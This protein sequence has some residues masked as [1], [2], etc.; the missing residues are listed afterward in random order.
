MVSLRQPFN[1]RLDFT[2]GAIIPEGAKVVRRLGDMRDMYQDREAVQR[3]LDGG[4]P[5]IYVVHNVEVP[6]DSGELQHCT[7][8]VYP[9]RVG[10]EFF[11]TKGHFHAKAGTA[12]IYLTLRG[13]G[14][15]L[16]QTQ[17]G[18]TATLDMFPGSVSYIP[19]YWAHRSINVGDEPL[20]F[21]AVYPGDA[22]HNYG[23]IEE[24][25]FAKIVVARGDDV[26]VVDNP[27]YGGCRT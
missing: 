17:D 18:A 10:D 7:S 3:L 24:K 25:G 26:A 15:L 19:P 16:M 5:L 14:L 22:G 8:V 13:K 11:M 1:T 9:G 2:A 27:R 20:V 23:V 21:F 6:E 12:E 4:D